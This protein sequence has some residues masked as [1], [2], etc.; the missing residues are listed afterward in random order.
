MAK[1][2]DELDRSIIKLLKDDGRIT[3]KAIAEATGSREPTVANRIRRLI[4][5]HV[6]EVTVQR[7]VRT[8]GLPLDA[9]AD[10]YVA[11][12][13]VAGISEQLGKCENAYVVCRLLGSPEI[14]VMFYA[15]D[16]EHVNE[17]CQ[18]EFASIDGVERI[19]LNIVLKTLKY[20]SRYGALRDAD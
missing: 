9:I 11:G 19:E 4:E 16:V 5:N 18:N 3:N 17:I 15:R 20:E 7:D 6:I 14:M 2:V 1:N 8:L 12:S 13:D 10:V